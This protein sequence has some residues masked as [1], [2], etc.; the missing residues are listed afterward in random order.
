MSENR[1]S[2][3]CPP[4]MHRSNESGCEQCPWHKLG[5]QSTPLDFCLCTPS[6]FCLVVF[7]IPREAISSKTICEFLSVSLSRE[8]EVHPLRRCAEY[9]TDLLAAFGVHHVFPL[10]RSSISQRPVCLRAGE[11]SF[12]RLVHKTSHNALYVCICELTMV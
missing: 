9:A 8:F 5:T 2:T 11:A 3:F 1:T 6:D 7:I 4:L 12:W 10:A